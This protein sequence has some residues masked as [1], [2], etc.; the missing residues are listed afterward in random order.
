METTKQQ[1]SK[2][3]IG[4]SFAEQVS[5]L[6]C[7]MLR[8]QGMKGTRDIERKLRLAL[9]PYFDHWCSLNRNERCHIYLAWEAYKEKH[10]VVKNYGYSLIAE[11]AIALL[12]RMIQTQRSKRIKSSIAEELSWLQD[13]VVKDMTNGTSQLREVMPMAG[14]EHLAFSKVVFIIELSSSIAVALSL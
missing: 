4:I 6:T 8:N 11:E 12:E 7:D 3:L 2:E 9:Y 1:L 5:T 10:G 13:I 14:L